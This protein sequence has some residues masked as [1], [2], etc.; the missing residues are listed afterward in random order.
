MSYIERIAGG[1]E[2]MLWI[3]YT[4]AAQVALDDPRLLNKLAQDVTR[5]RRIGAFDIITSFLERQPKVDELRKG[6]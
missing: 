5:K 4:P 3:C 1:L 2:E 6:L